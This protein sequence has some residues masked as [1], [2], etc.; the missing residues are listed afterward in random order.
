MPL[1]PSV[2][3]KVAFQIRPVPSKDPPLRRPPTTV[4]S[5]SGSK[6]TGTSEKVMETEVELVVSLRFVAVMSTV[7][8]GILVSTSKTNSV[9]YSCAE[10][11]FGL[12]NK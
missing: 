7:A 12:L 4:R 1:K 11:L 8:V 5:V 10:L 2:A 9:L 3:V 6:P